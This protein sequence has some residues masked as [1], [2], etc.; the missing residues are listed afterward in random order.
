MDLPD[1]ATSRRLAAAVAGGRLVLGVVAL[2][3]PSLPARPWVGA[4]ASGTAPVRVVGRGLGGRDLALA[5]GTLWALRNP[6]AGPRSEAAAWVAASALADG[7]DVLATLVSW[8]HLP[9]RG[10]LLVVAAALG[11]A[12]SGVAALPGLGGERGQQ[13]SDQR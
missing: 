1:T 2:S 11:A 8:R 9:R 7:A 6:W 5:A 4:A 10:R 3:R 13:G 12:A